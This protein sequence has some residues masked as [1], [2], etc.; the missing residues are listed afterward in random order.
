[1]KSFIVAA[2]AALVLMAC[3]QSSYPTDPQSRYPEQYPQQYPQQRQRDGLVTIIRVENNYNNNYEHLPPGQAK[4]RYGGRSARVYAPGQQR[5]NEYGSGIATVIAVPDRY[6]SR[7]NSGQFYY[8]YRGNTYW[9]QND[10]YYY[11]ANDYRR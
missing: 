11:I 7:S 2:S 4:K 10:G 5:K 1:M 3:S 9:K 8:N 6:A